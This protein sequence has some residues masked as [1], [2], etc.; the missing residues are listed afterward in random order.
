MYIDTFKK[1]FLVLIIVS[2]AL[3][4]GCATQAKVDAFTAMQKKAGVVYG[5]VNKVFDDD[6]LQKTC[7]SGK[8]DPEMLRAACSDVANSHLVQVG[9]LIDGVSHMRGEV[10]PKT[11][12]IEPG[13]IVKLDMLKPKGLHFAEIAARQETDTCKWTGHYNNMLDR[14]KLTNSGEVVGAFMLGASL[15]FVGG[16]AAI[17][18]SINTTGG[19]ECN[20][21][22]YKESFKDFLAAS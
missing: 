4:T 15:P 17:V 2:T 14:G 11:F 7:R 13:M 6:D 16:V 18:K 21:W 20:G 1:S 9:I 3:V 8:G 10:I 12:G 19:V 22:S 5:Q